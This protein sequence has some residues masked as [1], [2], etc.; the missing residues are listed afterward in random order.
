MNNSKPLACLSIDL[1]NQWSYM[2]THGDAGWEGF[3]SYFESLIP[4]VLE[5][6]DSFN[7]KITFFIVGQDAALEKNRNAL[8]MITRNGH[9]VG[10]HSFLHEPW[11]PFSP[12]EKIR[13]EIL[14][15]EKA[16]FNATGQRPAGYRGPGFSWSAETMNILAEMGYLYDASTFPAC[17]GPAGRLYYFS[18]SH[19]SA[20]AT[21]QRRNLFGNFRDGQRPVRP[22]LW[23]LPSKKRLLEIPVTTMPGF[24]LP[25]HQ[26]Y[27]V[28]LSLYSPP[29]MARYLDL[30]VSLCRRFR[31]GLSFLLH[32]L[33]FLG[34][35]EVPELAFFPGM[36]AGK[37]DKLRLFDKVIEKISGSFQI[38]DMKTYAKASLNHDRRLSLHTAYPKPLAAEFERG[39]T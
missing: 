3:P 22:Y 20:E 32:P 34:G 35:D 25:F 7:L 39:R 4:R 9:D 18:K 14:A 13:R 17:L 6:L 36:K 11:L 24:K 12:A 28:Y 15:A 5:R 1:D 8:A 10:N 33:D 23:L 26:S 21:R 37:D 29:L 19:L 2:K 31:T 16:I 38:V 27:L 30:A